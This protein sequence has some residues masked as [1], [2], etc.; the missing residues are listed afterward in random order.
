MKIISL[1]DDGVRFSESAYYR[2]LAHCFFQNSEADRELAM[3]IA[4]Y[5]TTRFRELG[6]ENYSMSEIGKL[7]F[8]SVEKRSA[9]M[10]ICGYVTIVMC[11]N[12]M[13][14]RSPSLYLASK[15]VSEMCHRYGKIELVSQ[16]NGKLEIRKIG[17]TDDPPSIQNI[18]REYRSVAH[19]CAARVS[20]VEYIEIPAIFDRAP[21]VENCIISTAAYFQQLMQEI[22]KS[23]EWE[24]WDVRSTLPEEAGDYPPL[25]P[26]QDKLN[27]IFEP[28]LTDQN[29][30]KSG[31]KRKG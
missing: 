4:N 26:S 28:Y 15:I 7:I 19:I 1:S 21:L 30:K 31:A 22:P 6:P 29:R 14:G 17:A 12:K 24:L 3:L 5:E 2:M 9:R 10:A 18:F 27:L 20:C 11:F 13:F 16:I 25:L 8:L 23:S